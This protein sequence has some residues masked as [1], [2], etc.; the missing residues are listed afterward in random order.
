MTAAPKKENGGDAFPGRRA[1]TPDGGLYVRG[2]CKSFEKTPV[3]TNVSLQVA[4]GEFVCILGPSGCGKTTLLRIVAGLETPDDGR[5]FIGGDDMT[6][7]PTAGRGV[8]IVFQSYA[9]FPNLTALQNVAFGM[10]RREA[11]ASS[12]PQKALELLDL[13]G[14]TESAQKYPCQLSGGQQQRVALARALAPEPSILLLDEPL[15]ALDA[16]VRQSLRKEIRRLQ[17]R[18]GITAVMVTHDQEEALTMSDR[19]VVMHKGRLTQFASPEEIYR[20]PSTRFVADFIGAMNFLEGWLVE[21]G[22][23]HYGGI[24]I[25][26]PAPTGADGSLVTLAVRP[27]D[28][29]IGLD[30]FPDEN[31]FAATVAEMEFRGAGYYLTLKA[32]TTLRALTDDGKG[33]MRLEALLSPLRASQLKIGAG[34]CV[35]VRLPRERLICFAQDGTAVDFAGWGPQ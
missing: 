35:K 12:I 8:G 24:D 2:V 6:R 3:L 32:L 23:A 5:V 4:R 16:K 33:G 11:G 9:L 1:E 18:L 22:I 34:D 10:R 30:S 14:L 28:V 17:R 21:G 13:V 7:I 31:A 19:M 15:S 26:L 25:R 20:L 29:Q 27:E